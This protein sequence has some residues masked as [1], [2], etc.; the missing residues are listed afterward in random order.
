MGGADYCWVEERVKQTYKGGSNVR[1]KNY[2]IIGQEKEK[3]WVRISTIPLH[4]TILRA[5]RMNIIVEEKGVK[6]GK[7][8]LLVT[9]GP[10][11][12]VDVLATKKQLQFY[13]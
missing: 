8:A 6:I 2:K 3:I 10:V 12:T 9:L 13:L 7:D 11:R 4:S 5:E 1:R